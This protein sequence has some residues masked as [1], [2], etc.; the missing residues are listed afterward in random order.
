MDHFRFH[1]SLIC[2]ETDMRSVSGFLS[3]VSRIMRKKLN[4]EDKPVEII[5]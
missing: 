5:I 1:K 4:A 2:P 3:E